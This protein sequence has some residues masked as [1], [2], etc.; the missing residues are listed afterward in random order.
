MTKRWSP[1]EKKRR[2]KNGPKVKAKRETVQTRVLLS[3]TLLELSAPMSAS[4]PVP[5]LS[6]AVP[7]LS[8][9]ASTSL[10]MPGSSAAMFR[11]FASASECVHMPRLFA[12]E[13]GLSVT[14][15]GLSAIVH[16]LSG[17]SVAGP[18]SSVPVSTSILG[19]RLSAAVPALSGP[20]Y[21]SV[22]GPRL[23]VP[24]PGLS[25]LKTPTPDFAAKRQNLDDTISE[26]SV[27]S[28][29]ASSKALYSGKIKMTALEK[30]FL[31]RTPLFLLFF[32]SSGISKRKFDKFFINTWP[33]ASNYAK[34]E[35]DISFVVGGYPPAVQSNRP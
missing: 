6:A 19:L 33:L 3:A 31:P 32:L 27:K 5:R 22:F 9:P 21:T 20:A 1:I 10:P 11:L 2:A 28:K 17:F 29:K 4:D 26:W 24:R 23:S 25:L 34:K 18:G 7:D 8:T 14:M 13:P 12:A 35:V 15:P 16:G 30:I